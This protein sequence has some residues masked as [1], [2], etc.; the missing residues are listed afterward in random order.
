R[1]AENATISLGTNP[2]RA[3]SVSGN[4]HLNYDYRTASLA[5]DLWSDAVLLVGGRL[6]L[7]LHTG[8]TQWRGRQRWID[9]GPHSGLPLFGKLDL[10][11]V[12]LTLRGT[13]AFDRD[14]TLQLFS[15]LLRSG[16]RY[17]HLYDLA[18]PRTFIPCDA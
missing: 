15:Q 3:F 5:Y 9:T 13:L 4:A 6:Q 7:G 11:Q 2:A 17:E 8:F 10:N 16:Q 1:S 14:L 12:E 18:D